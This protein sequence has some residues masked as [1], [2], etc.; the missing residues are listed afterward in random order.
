MK[1]QV[2]SGRLAIVRLPP[3]SAVPAWAAVG[4]Q[5]PD[6]PDLCSDTCSTGDFQG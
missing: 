1:L 6:G 3:D 5:R 2:L 4:G